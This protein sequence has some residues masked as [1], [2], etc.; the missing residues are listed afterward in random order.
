MSKIR[1]ALACVV[2]M[3]VSASCEEVTVWQNDDDLMHLWLNG[4]DE[5][6]KCESWEFHTDRDGEHASNQVLDGDTISFVSKAVTWKTNDYKLVIE[7]YG[8]DTYSY[9]IIGDSLILDIMGEVTK[10]AKQ[11]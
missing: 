3:F 10:F 5:D 6:G 11:N 4:P 8:F 9:E 1:V 2:V 7:S